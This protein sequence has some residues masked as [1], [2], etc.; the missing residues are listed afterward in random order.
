MR[1]TWSAV[2]IAFVVFDT[3]GALYLKNRVAASPGVV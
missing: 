1:F 2:W 3:L